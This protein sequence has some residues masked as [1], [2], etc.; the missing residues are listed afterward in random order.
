MLSKRKIPPRNFRIYFVHVKVESYKVITKKIDNVIPV[1]G[2]RALDGG[3]WS[4]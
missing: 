3:E 2:M 1:H 4:K